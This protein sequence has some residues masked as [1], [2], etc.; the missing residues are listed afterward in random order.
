MA[1]L[2]LSLSLSLSLYSEQ[3]PLTDRLLHVTQQVA[4]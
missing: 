4:D 1:F 3:G 2:S